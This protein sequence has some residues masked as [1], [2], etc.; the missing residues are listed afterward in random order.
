MVFSHILK[1][2][3][4]T[5]L[6]DYSLLVSSSGL[7]IWGNSS[8]LMCGEYHFLTSAVGLMHFP[9]VRVYGIAVFAV[10]LIH[11]ALFCQPNKVQVLFQGVL[12]FAGCGKC[13]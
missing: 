2:L 6:L 5:N 4:E 13:Y 11:C 10:F 7:F 9:L 3:P 12:C 1:R 8:Q